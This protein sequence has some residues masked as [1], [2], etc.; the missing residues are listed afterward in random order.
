MTNSD[1]RAQSIIDELRAQIT[2]LSARCAEVAVE[3]DAAVAKIA[4]YNRT[5]KEAL[6]YEPATPEPKAKPKPKPA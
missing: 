4:E 3:R 1:T 2:I 5:A 6:E